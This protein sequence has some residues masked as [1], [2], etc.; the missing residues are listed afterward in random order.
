MMNG[1]IDGHGASTDSP[2]EALAADQ[3]AVPVKRRRRIDKGL[4][5]VSILI[6]LGLALVGRGLLVGVTGDE[7]SDLPDQIE[8]VD[9]VPEAV[10]VLSQTAVFVDLV[11]GYTGVLVIDEI[12]IPTADVGEVA[13]QA[14]FEP[15]QQV[16]LPPVTI[17]EPGN[18]T[19]TFTPGDE[20]LITEF[21]SGQHQAQ[22][23]FWRPEEGREKARSYTWTFT[24]V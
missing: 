20:A 14:G 7:R 4:L 22:V 9:P 17:Y 11:D 10:Q 6:A 8:A 2:T 23:V 5:A 16:D 1:V 21:T 12:E 19:L 15:G 24:V 18:S 13:G 3:Q